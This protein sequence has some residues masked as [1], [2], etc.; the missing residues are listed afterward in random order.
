MTALVK[1]DDRRKWIEDRETLTRVSLDDLR[2]MLAS[3][4]EIT[5]HHISKMALIWAELE[6]RGEDMT[7]LR[8]GIARYLPAA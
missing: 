6:R 8:S 7:A 2:K 4:I 3:E 1:I 5:A